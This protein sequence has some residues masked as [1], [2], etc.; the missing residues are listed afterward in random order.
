MGQILC[1][2]VPGEGGR[3]ASLTEAFA[4]DAHG[5]TRDRLGG[6]MGLA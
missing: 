1:R 6:P 2:G 5:G 4:K 3:G